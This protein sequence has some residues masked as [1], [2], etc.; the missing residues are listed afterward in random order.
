MF[1]KLFFQYTFVPLNV[2]KYQIM[3]KVIRT[4][5][6]SLLAVTVFTTLLGNASEISPLSTKE[7][8][9]KT[10]LT[11]NNVKAGDL[12]TIKDYEGIIL[13]KELINISGTYKKGFDLTALPN[14][15]YFF[16][17]NKDMEIRTIPF[18][19][20]SS[21]VVFNKSE[22]EITFKPFVRQKA[23]LV[24]ITKLATNL[25]PLKVEIYTQVNGSFELA[26]SEK[27]EGTQTIERAYKLEKGNYKVVLNSNNNEFTK[28][29]NN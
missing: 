3:K 13:Y 23:N 19:V 15:S 22:E 14:G 1:S 28:F 16:E 26:Y 11:I 6:K 25:E 17:I 21:E 27:V 24:L 5:Q 8:L 12:L 4:I 20:K 7:E 10:A 9:K 29:I 2:I 18:T